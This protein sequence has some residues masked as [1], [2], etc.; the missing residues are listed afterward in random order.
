VDQEEVELLEAEVLESLVE[1][2][3]HVVG[4][5]VAVAEFALPTPCSVP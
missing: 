5:V 2:T 1:R 3:P 4:T